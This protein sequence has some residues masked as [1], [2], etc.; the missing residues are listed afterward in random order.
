VVLICLYSCETIVDINLD[1]ADNQVVVNA[2]IT[3]DTAINVNLSLTKPL[4][5][6]GDTLFEDIQNAQV[7]LF[8]NNNPIGIMVNLG[9]GL[10]S[11]PEYFACTESQYKIEFKYLGKTISGETEIP[12]PISIDSIDFISN[13]GV[14]EFGDKYHLLKTSFRDPGTTT[15][16][17]EIAVKFEYLDSVRFFGYLTD[18][19]TL[20]S[21]DNIIANEIDTRNPG[22]W[23]DHLVFSDELFSSDTITISINCS[24]LLQS[25]FLTKQRI[26]VFL[27]TISKEYY[28]Y[29]KKLLLYKQSTSNEV[30]EDI[31]EPVIMYSNIMNGYGIFAGYSTDTL[32]FVIDE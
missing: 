13:F 7:F 11:I 9:E 27:N 16:Y 21:N 2:L 25:G 14:T 32:S 31:S 26:T 18:Y 19:F 4:F 1:S 23:S 20:F 15:N 10:Y 29:N 3:N 22:F 5:Q 24:S 12:A 28:L 6:E 8:E 17:Y 30:W